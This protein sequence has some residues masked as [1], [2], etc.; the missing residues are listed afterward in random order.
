[1][2]TGGKN[3]EIIQNQNLLGGHA[4]D[5]SNDTAT[6]L[7]GDQFSSLN[8]TSLQQEDEIYGLD[9]SAEEEKIRQ[10]AITRA[11]ASRELKNE[12]PY[13]IYENQFPFL[14]QYDE[15]YY[16][17]T[18]FNQWT[19]TRYF[20]PDM[21]QE[22]IANEYSDGEWDLSQDNKVQLTQDL[23]KAMDTENN[24]FTFKLGIFYEFTRELPADFRKSEGTQFKTLNMS[25]KFDCETG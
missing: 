4:L 2:G 19:E 9:S 6:L 14:R 22:C 25:N 24:D 10:E 3:H 12:I 13:V 7:D 5:F 15:D 11:K 23:Q 8:V 20:T 18:K 21:L 1:M 17:L 16:K